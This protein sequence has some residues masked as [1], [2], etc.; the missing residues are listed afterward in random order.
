MFLN[1]DIM[2]TFQ[3]KKNHFYAMVDFSDGAH[4]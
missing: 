2:T 3:G 4:P 1:A